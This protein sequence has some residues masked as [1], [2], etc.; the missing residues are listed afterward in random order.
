[1]KEIMMMR[2]Q[3]SAL[4][5]KQPIP[6]HVAERLESEWRQVRESAPAVTTKR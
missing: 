5:V 3:A 1:M 4:P 2:Q 6:Q